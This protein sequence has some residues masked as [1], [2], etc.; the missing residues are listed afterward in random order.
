MIGTRLSYV[1]DLPSPTD[2]INDSDGNFCANN[3]M[4]KS[5]PPLPADAIPKGHTV[6][7]VPTF[8]ATVCPLGINCQ[9]PLHEKHLERILLHIL[10]LLINNHLIA[11]YCE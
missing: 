11:I 9:A 8:R 1:F 10:L 3:R 6:N 5:S 4:D 7:R 2:A